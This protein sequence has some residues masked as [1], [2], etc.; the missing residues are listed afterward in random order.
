MTNTN[1]IDITF[2]DVTIKGLPLGVKVTITGAFGGTR[3]IETTLPPTA[4]SIPDHVRV[5]VFGGV[6][7]DASS[8]K[9]NHILGIKEVRAAT[10]L[11]LKEAK[12]FMDAVRGQRG[13]DV[14]DRAQ[15]IGATTMVTDAIHVEKAQVLASALRA[16]GLN[17]VLV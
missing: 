3:S 10:G 4:S 5:R 15:Y 17:A 16:M 1:T 14:G 11:G 2:D 13:P 7:F 8:P 6:G 9:Y 12:D